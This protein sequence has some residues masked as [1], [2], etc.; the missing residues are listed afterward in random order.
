MNWKLEIVFAIFGKEYF[1]EDNEQPNEI[2]K[3][4]PHL[5]AIRLS[6]FYCALRTNLEGPLTP[7]QTHLLDQAK[8]QGNILDYCARQVVSK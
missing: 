8:E 4:F 6:H 1:T 7:G 2:E 5:H 3:E